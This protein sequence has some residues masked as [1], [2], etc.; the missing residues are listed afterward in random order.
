MCIRDRVGDATRCKF[1]DCH[2]VDVTI[3][4]AG[5]CGGFV[6]NAVSSSFES[7]SYTQL[8]MI[9]TW[10]PLNPMELKYCPIR[11]HKLPRGQYMKKYNIHLFRSL[12]RCISQSIFFSLTAIYSISDKP[13]A[14][15]NHTNIL[16]VEILLIVAIR[17]FIMYFA[18]L[19]AI[20]L[21]LIHI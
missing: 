7:V 16:E 17:T 11:G 19:L 18:V 5:N 8:V 21:S 13:P 12:P 10:V 1:T 9:P 4:G 2:V 20:R 15:N 6:G 3:T 14:N